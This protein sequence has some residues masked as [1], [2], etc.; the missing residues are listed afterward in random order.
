MVWG[1]RPGPVGGQEEPASTPHPPAGRVRQFLPSGRGCLPR[2]RKRGMETVVVS[3]PLRFRGC[4]HGELSSPLQP[5]T[6]G[7]LIGQLACPGS[8]S[9]RP[10]A[11]PAGGGEPWGRRRRPSRRFDAHAARRAAPAGQA[12]AGTAPPYGGR[13]GLFCG[14]RSPPSGGAPLPRQG[15]RL[16]R[17]PCT[18]S[19]FPA[20]RGGRPGRLPGQGRRWRH[21]ESGLLPWFGAAPVGQTDAAPGQPRRL[22][23]SRRGQPLPCVG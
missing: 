22:D 14:R 5:T 13:L 15:R 18:R 19:R 12:G 8:P 23:Q 17:Q 16:S 7:S 9:D 3:M 4:Q 20:P 1:P 2:K 10:P 11:S 6:V 21:A